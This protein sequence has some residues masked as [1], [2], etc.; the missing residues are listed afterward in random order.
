MIIRFIFFKVD[1]KSHKQV[2]R[3][4]VVIYLTEL[5]QLVSLF[6]NNPQFINDNT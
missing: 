1:S 4:T 6:F 2:V 5:Q 3:V